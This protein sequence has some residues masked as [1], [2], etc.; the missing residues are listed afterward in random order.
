M[1]L[2]HHDGT[3]YFSFIRA[4]IVRFRGLEGVAGLV[5]GALVIKL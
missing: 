4:P 3:V 5:G 1:Q 2:G